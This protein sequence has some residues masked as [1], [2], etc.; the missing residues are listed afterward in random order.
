MTLKE[1]DVYLTGR[2]SARAHDKEEAIKMVTKK[3]DVIHPM[4]N[5]QVMVAKEDYL[6]AGEDYKPEGTE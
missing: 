4:F 6:H 5:I 2:I 3:L 1:F